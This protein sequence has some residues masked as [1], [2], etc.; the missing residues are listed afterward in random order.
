MQMR[1]SLVLP[2][3]V[4]SVGGTEYDEIG[5]CSRAT[6]GDVLVKDV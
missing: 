5:P 4:A 6:A 1:A 3:H 2:H